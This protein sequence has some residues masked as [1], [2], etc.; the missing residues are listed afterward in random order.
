MPIIYPAVPMNA[1]RIRTSITAEH[2]QQHLDF[3]LDVLAQAGRDV[4]FI[5]E[6]G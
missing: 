3:A 6:T 2:T 5:T 4:G 1:P